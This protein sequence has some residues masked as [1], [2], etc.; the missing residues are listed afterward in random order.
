V[1]L[2][3]RFELLSIVVSFVTFFCGQFLFVDLTSGER[4]L[5]SAIIV[6]FNAVFLLGISGYIA[7]FLY[8]R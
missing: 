1:P 7:K 2:F 3:D 5:M 8:M 6:T 4:V